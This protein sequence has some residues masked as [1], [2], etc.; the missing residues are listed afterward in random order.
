MEYYHPQ[1]GKLLD[2]GRGGRNPLHVRRG[3]RGVFETYGRE[4]YHNPL[5]ESLLPYLGWREWKALL[6]APMGVYVVNR[7]GERLAREAFGR[8][9]LFDL[10]GEAF[11]D[12]STLADVPLTVG[13]PVAFKARDVFFF[14]PEKSYPDKIAKYVAE[15]TF[16]GLT[17][18]IRRYYNSREGI[19]HRAAAHLM[20]L[21]GKAVAL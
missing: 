9:L 6:Q 14:L 19:Q 4:L 20:A 2:V 17:E 7:L 12:I 16:Q 15:W 5:Y 21:A 18:G 11:R 10:Y 13:M 8:Y 3:G 1:C